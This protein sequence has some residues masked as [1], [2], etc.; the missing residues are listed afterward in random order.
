MIGAHGGRPAPRVGAAI[1]ALMQE[2]GC[3]PAA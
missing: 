3:V 1:P 2:S